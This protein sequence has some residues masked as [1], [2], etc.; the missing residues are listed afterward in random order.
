LDGNTQLVH[1][2]FKLVQVPY[3]YLVVRRLTGK[4]GMHYTMNL[5]KSYIIGRHSGYVGIIGRHL[6]AELRCTFTLLLIF[7]FSRKSG[8]RAI[9]GFLKVFFNVVNLISVIHQ[10]AKQIFYLLPNSSQ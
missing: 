2:L 9:W 6:M 3:F 1:T 10:V 4:H 5:G 7:I 8:N